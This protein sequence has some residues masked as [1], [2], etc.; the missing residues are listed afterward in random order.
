MNPVVYQNP[1]K[2]LTG[3][4]FWDELSHVPQTIESH[5]P[6]FDHS[7]DAYFDRRFAAIIEEW[8]LLTDSDLHRLEKRLERVSDD[9]S[10][11]YA[12]KMALE[13]RAKDLEN[14]ITSLEKSL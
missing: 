8:D 10:G 6:T 4:S 9:I 5:I 1:E 11:L 14:L 2:D 12:G 3:S 7:L 13:S